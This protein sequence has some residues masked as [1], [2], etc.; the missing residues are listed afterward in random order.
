M[1]II[2]AG[3]PGSGKSYFAGRLSECLSAL[4]FSSDQFRKI[5]FTGIKYSPDE[6]LAVYEK[7]LSETLK[8]ANSKKNIVLDG[9]FYKKSIREKFRA[10][11]LANNQKIIFIEIRAESELIKDRL[12][13]IRKDSDADYEVYQKLLTEFEPLEENHLT[14]FSEMDNVEYMLKE[15]LDYISKNS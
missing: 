1:V 13:G 9:T 11:L 14:L 15:S 3:L 2:I 7:L 10:A 8:A 4:Y 6:K 12:K 5:F